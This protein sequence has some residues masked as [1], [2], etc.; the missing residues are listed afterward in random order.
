MLRPAPEPCDPGPPTRVGREPCVRRGYLHLGSRA[1]TIVREPPVGAA[2][3]TFGGMGK[4][5]AMA[6]VAYCMKCREKREFTGSLVTLANGRPALQGTCPVCGTKLTKIMGM[7]AA[8]AMG[9][10]AP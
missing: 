5:T 7:D 3:E 4:E 8:K 1:T 9:W 6:D 10:K 2:R